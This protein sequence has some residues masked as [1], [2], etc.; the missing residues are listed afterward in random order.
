MVESRTHCV[1][2]RP[3]SARQGWHCV[4][5]KDLW[6]SQGPHGVLFKGCMVCESRVFVVES[7]TALCHS[8][9]AFCVNQAPPAAAR[10]ILMLP[11]D[12]SLAHTLAARPFV[13]CVRGHTP[14]T[15]RPFLGCARGHTSY[16]LFCR[17]HSRAPSPMQA[18]LEVIPTRACRQHARSY[19]CAG[20]T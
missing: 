14:Y 18:A 11:S 10:A 2:Q 12:L 8:R 16:P 6:L 7:T 1:S 15:V 17:L 5:V 19:S 3:H 4:C 20:C 9:A 13:G